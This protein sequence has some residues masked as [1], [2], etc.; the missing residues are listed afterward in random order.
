MNAIINV[1]EIIMPHIIGGMVIV[2]LM[3]EG[4]FF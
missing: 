4:P 2:V 3:P 1:T